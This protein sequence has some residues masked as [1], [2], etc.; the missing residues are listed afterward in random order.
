MKKETI[1]LEE[2]K[3]VGITIRTTYQNELDHTTS[4]I[5]PCVARYFQD[6]IA[7]RI[8]H[9]KNPE[10]TLCAYTN[11]ENEYKGAYTFFIGQEVNSLGKLPEGLEALTVPAQTY[12]KLTTD[13]GPIPQVIVEAWQQIWQM[14]PGDLGGTR[15]YKVDFQVYDDRAI[16]PQNAI[17]DIYVGIKKGVY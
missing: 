8:P 17:V 1:T 10:V 16:D 6:Q 15:Q 13:K 2:K 11:Y 7:Q 14:S 12:V 9:V 4:H 3:L 5:G